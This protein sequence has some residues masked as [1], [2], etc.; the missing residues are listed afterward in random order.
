MADCP[1]SFAGAFISI[2][3][4]FLHPRVRLLGLGLLYFLFSLGYPR[5]LCRGKIQ[6]ILLSILH[7]PKTFYWIIYNIIFPLSYYNKP[8]SLL[9]TT[10]SIS[11]SIQSS[12]IIYHLLSDPEITAIYTPIRPVSTLGVFTYWVIQKLPQF[13]FISPVST[14][15]IFTYWVTQQF[16]QFALIMPVFTHGV[17]T[18]WVTHNLP[19]FSPIRPLSL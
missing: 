3:L 18:Y 12:Q 17:F 9:L 14:N 10:I 4:R 7:K 13:A 11:N 2:Q 19:Q 6:L 5:P 8:H 16:P 1:A 15:G